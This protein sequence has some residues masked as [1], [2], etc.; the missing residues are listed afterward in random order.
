MALSIEILEKAKLGLEA[1]DVESKIDNDTL[2]LCIDG[3]SF[4]LAE[5]EIFFQSLEY[6]RLLK[7]EEENFED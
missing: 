2:Y 6:D 7:E 4:E 5:Y 1:K 3:M